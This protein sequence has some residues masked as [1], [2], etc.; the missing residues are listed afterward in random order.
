MHVFKLRFN[1]HKSSSI[2]PNIISNDYTTNR[3][4]NY[5]GI[6]MVMG[7]EITHGFDDEGLYKA[8]NYQYE[9]KVKM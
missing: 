4:L 6:G 8:P 9:E 2:T 5:G 7:H 1:I 3:S